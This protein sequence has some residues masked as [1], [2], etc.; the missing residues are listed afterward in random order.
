MLLLNFS[1][2]LTDAQRAQIETLTGQS[3]AEVRDIASHFENGQPFG[4]QIRALVAG[5]DL[6]PQD[7]QTRSIVVN[8]PAYN[9]AA[10]TL[11]AELHGRMG[12]F[13]A[14]LRVRSIPHSTPP[15]YEAAE[16]INLQAIRDTARQTRKEN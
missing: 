14:I 9:F 2:P 15:R 7:W 5:I 12:Y 13:P 4:E 16:I 3:I 1:H 10:V 6:T 11:L 8:P